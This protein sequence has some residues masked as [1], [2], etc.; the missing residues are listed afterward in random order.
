MR[1]HQRAVTWQTKA[2]ATEEEE[3]IEYFTE[4]VEIAAKLMVGV[5]I[6]AGS[7]LAAI[8]AGRAIGAAL[9]RIWLFITRQT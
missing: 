4:A 5:G 1:F 6:I 8:L 3:M 7:I 9:W 2:Q